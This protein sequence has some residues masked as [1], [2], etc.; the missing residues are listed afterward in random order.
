[1][2]IRRWVARVLLVPTLCWNLLLAR[3]LHLRH[4]WD[5]IDAGVYLGALPLARD[6]PRWHALGVNAVVNMCEEYAGPEA[7]YRRAG[8]EQLRLPTVDFTAPSLDQVQRGVAFITDQRARG[9]G[10]Y[11]HCKAGRARS[12]TVVLCWLVATRGMS[13]GAAQAWILA[14]RP[15]VHPRLARRAVVQQFCAA[16]RDRPESGALSL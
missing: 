11:V 6:V 16:L 4:W 10:V 3:V 14:R 12:A 1:M 9:R 5:Q 13:P 8:I 2:L 7:A 15:H